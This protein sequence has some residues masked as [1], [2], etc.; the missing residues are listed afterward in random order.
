[1]STNGT[2][3]E[4]IS[5]S[6]LRTASAVPWYQSVVVRVCFG[7]PDLHPAGVED[8]EVIGLGDVAVQGDG[9]ELGEDGDLVMPELMQLLMGM[10][11]RRYFPAMGTAGL[12]RSLV[13][14]YR[15]VPCPRRG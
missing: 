9:I 1:M 10:S 8:V 4:W 3:A 11:M 7:R 13:S 14:G 12:A 6:C 2:R 15:R 5:N